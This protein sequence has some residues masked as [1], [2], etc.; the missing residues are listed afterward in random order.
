MQFE[1]TILI[2]CL[3]IPLLCCSDLGRSRWFFR[4]TFFHTRLYE[5]S[6]LIISG[7][8]WSTNQLEAVQF[9]KVIILCLKKLKI[10]KQKDLSLLSYYYN[11]KTKWFLGITSWTDKKPVD[12]NTI[13]WKNAITGTAKISVLVRVFWMSIVVRTINLFVLFLQCFFKSLSE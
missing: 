6:G 11:L 1:A 9:T 5:K 7:K 10:S 2:P 13:T 8:A 12:I 4:F 3:D